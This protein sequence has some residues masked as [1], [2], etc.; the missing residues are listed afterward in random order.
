LVRLGDSIAAGFGI[1]VGVELELA[2]TVDVL[3]TALELR[4]VMVEAVD[5]V[6]AA[7]AAAAVEQ[8]RECL[9]N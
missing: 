9:Q 7:A 2:G 3:H 5:T 4:P 1:E 8:T 6:A